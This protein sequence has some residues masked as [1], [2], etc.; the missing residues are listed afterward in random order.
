MI[1]S[2]YGFSLGDRVRFVED[3][4]PD[5]GVKFDDTGV[6]CN[7]RDDYEDGAVGVRWDR[8]N[9]SFHDCNGTC[10]NNHGWYVPYQQIIL[11]V[12]DGGDLAIEDGDLDALLEE[13]E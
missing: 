5:N 2:K 8:K 7:L 3:R 1:F 13:F 12:V 11:D 9:L 6:I 10:E 4:D